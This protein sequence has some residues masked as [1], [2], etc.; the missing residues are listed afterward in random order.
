[1]IILLLILFVIFLGIVFV[2]AVSSIET[3]TWIIIGVGCVL[4]IAAVIAVSHLVKVLRKP[5]ACK[6]CGQITQGVDQIKYGWGIP[7]PFIIC[8][9]CDSKVHPQIIRYAK[10]HW[11]YNDF[12]EYLKWD[13]ETKQQRS[14][15]V[16]T[17]KYGSEA[18]I[19]VDKIHGLFSIGKTK[20]LKAEPGII[21]RFEDIADYKL[22]FKP[23]EIKD[24]VMGAKVRGTEMV[25]VS[26]SRPVVTIEEA[27]NSAAEY[28]L[29]KK[30]FLSNE[31][32]YQLSEEF[33]KVIEAFNSCIIGVMKDKTEA[34]INENK[35]TDET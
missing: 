21:F 28:S 20:L 2:A 1:M 33:Q 23:D 26:M 25:Q 10:E 9:N 13:E 4:L 16:I 11:N 14:Q 22:D 6:C 8:K 5:V 32:E 24:G 31:S 29:R 12:S 35:N 18:V 30:G 15:F 19:M 17:D 27:L 7:D 34:I 3:G